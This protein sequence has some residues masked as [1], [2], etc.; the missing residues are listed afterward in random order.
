M[1]SLMESLYSGIPN[2][3]ATVESLMESL[4]SGVLMESLQWSL[5]IVESLYSGFP[6]GVPVQWSP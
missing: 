2:G 5:C 6:N 3:V 1:K 4:Y